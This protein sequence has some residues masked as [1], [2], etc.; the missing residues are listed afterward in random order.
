MKL[1]LWMA[2]PLLLL[3]ACQAKEPAPAPAQS[4]TL[5]GAPLAALGTGEGEVSIVAWPG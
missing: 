3:I 5:K 2:A 1:K 4:V